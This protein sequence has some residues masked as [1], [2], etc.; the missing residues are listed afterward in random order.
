MNRPTTLRGRSA[1]IIATAL[2][3]STTTTLAAMV[4][5]PT[6]E[7]NRLFDSNDFAFATLAGPSGEFACFT[8]GALSACT[9]AML[10]IAALGPDLT[11]GLALGLDGA[12]T[13]ALPGTGSSVALW[14]AGNFSLHDDVD[15]LLV[16]VHTVAGWT[17]FRSLGSGVMAPVLNDSWPSG[18]QTNFGTLSAANF[19]LELGD[20]LDGVRFEACCGDD[21]D[22]D[23]LAVTGFVPV[24]PVPEPSSTALLLSGLFALGFLARRRKIA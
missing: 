2:F 23:V 8:G 21:S 20:L 3:L 11:T 16:S 14:E 18:Y 22:F 7:G 10:N 5:M 6:P 24:T 13:L 15:D 4:S 9:P 12:V 17:A 1:W 19:G